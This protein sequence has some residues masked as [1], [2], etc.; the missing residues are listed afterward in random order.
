MLGM[1]IQDTRS[2]TAN[3][4]MTLAVVLPA[5]NEGAS[6]GSLIATIRQHSARVGWGRVSIIVV[7][8]G[9]TDG[10]VA[11]VRATANRHTK[12]VQHGGNK[13]LGAAI[14]TGLLTAL[15]L[16]PT[17]DVLVTMDSDN[18]HLPALMQQMVAT[19]STGRDVVIAS[20][21]QRG[22]SVRGL[23]WHRQALSLGLSFLYR[24]FIPIPGVRDFSCGYRAYRASKL[25][26]AFDYWGDDFVNQSGFSCMV[27]ILLKLH[28]LGA[29][30]CE[31]PM[32]LRYDNKKGKSKM[33]VLRTVKE[34]LIIAARE[35]KQRWKDLEP[36]G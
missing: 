22:S 16:K 36:H 1:G 11:A 8:D 31:V 21:Y 20:R 35:M 23:A 7:D 5:F 2:P 9:S 34:T 25:T 15:K 10:T 14:K 6:I 4:P 30:V 19:I 3:R 27:D 12:L 32:T 26:E 28:R 33:P 18:T 13:G 17:P 24:A 29:T